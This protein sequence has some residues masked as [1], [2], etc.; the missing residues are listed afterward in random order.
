MKFFYPIPLCVL[1]C[2]H[3]VLF[4][5]SERTQIQMVGSD[6]FP[7]EQEFKELHRIDS[8]DDAQDKSS[9]PDASEAALVAEAGYLRYARRSFE[10]EGGGKMTVEVLRAK[11]ERSAYSLFSLLRTDGTNPGPPGESFAETG[12]ALT[13]VKGGF[14][15]RVA[16]PNPG[17]LLKRVATSVSNRI[18]PRDQ[19]VPSLVSHLP[20][21]GLLES[22]TRYF[23][24]PQAFDI[25]A[26]KPPGLQFDFQPEME[27]AQ[28]E[29]DLNAQREFCP[30]CIFPPGR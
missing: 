11:D 9:L 19:I 12:N 6:Y 16:G 23:L 22:T 4:S 26:S 17:S 24:G 5:A 20:S 29:Y 25:L 3:A 10:V 18:G 8:K 27:I 14:W 30:Y 15:V 13:F 7:A 28:A 2:C 21:T 1:L